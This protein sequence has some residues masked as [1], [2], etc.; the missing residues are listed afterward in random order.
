MTRHDILSTYDFNELDIISSP[1]KFEGEPIWAPYFWESF[2]MGD[3]DDDD[4]TVLTF[5]VTDTDRKEFPELNDVAQVLLQETES[6]FVYSSTVS[7]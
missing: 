1:G 4:D 2:L 3:A 7:V 6:G 5:N